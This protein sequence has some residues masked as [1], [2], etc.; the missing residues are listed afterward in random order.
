MH[1][2]LDFRIDIPPSILKEQIDSN[3]NLSNL[4]LS[5]KTQI[6]QEVLNKLSTLILSLSCVF[7]EDDTID[8]ELMYINNLSIVQNTDRYI[9]NGFLDENYE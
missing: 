6:E 8:S 7:D 5:Q 9:V 4:T 3:Q 1:K 2:L